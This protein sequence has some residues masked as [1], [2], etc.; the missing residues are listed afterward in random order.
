MVDRSPEGTEFWRQLVEPLREK[1]RDCKV[2]CT[3]TCVNLRSSLLRERD[4]PHTGTKLEMARRRLAFFF[5]FFHRTRKAHAAGARPPA[6]T[7]YILETI[8]T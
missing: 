1:L 4:I 5:F 8:K 2:V 6:T 7:G 3:L